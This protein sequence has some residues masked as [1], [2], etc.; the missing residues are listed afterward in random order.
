VAWNPKKN[1]ICAECSQ[2]FYY[3]REWLEDL[4]DVDGVEA[5]SADLE[6]EKISY[7]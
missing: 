7:F 4:V 5:A 3:R 6:S 1:Y 2:D